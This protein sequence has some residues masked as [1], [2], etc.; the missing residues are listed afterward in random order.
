MNIFFH[1]VAKISKDDFLQTQNIGK[2]TRFRVVF[3]TDK[4][5]WAPAKYRAYK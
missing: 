5:F 2:A 4:Y 3:S 1:F